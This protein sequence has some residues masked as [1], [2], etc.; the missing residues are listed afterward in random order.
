M[1][2]FI[3]PEKTGLIFAAKSAKA[4]EEMLIRAAMLRPILLDLFDSHPSTSSVVY[5]AEDP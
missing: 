3:E 5:Y 1:T 2:E 4:I